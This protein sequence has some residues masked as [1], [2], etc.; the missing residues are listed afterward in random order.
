[1]Q[2]TGL[3]AQAL[4][5]NGVSGYFG[6]LTKDAVIEFQKAKGISP[7]VGYVGVKTRAYIVAN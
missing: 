5:K 7:A 1:A 3:A 4:A 6:Q 2:N